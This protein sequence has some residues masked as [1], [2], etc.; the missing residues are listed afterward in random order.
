MTQKQKEIQ[1][2]V[3]AG[4]LVFSLFADSLFSY[5]H[6]GYEHSMDMEQ[7]TGQHWVQDLKGNPLGDY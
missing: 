5:K 3:V 7:K 4:L 6:I 1:G 2:Y